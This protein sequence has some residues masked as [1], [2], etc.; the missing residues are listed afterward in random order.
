[1]FDP[2]SSWALVEKLRATTPL[3]QCL[4]NFVSMDVTANVLLAAGASPAMVHDAEESG[5]FVALGGMLSINIGTPSP[6][7]VEGMVA[8][9][10]AAK[11]R[12]TPW[13]LDPVAVGATPYRDRIV[14]S[15]LA[16]RPALIRG[17]GSE[18]MA[19]AGRDDAGVTGVDSSRS[20]A[21]ARGAAIALARRLGAN[22]LVTGKDDLA[23]DGR[24]VVRIANGHPLMT[25]VTALG[26]ALTGVSAAFMAVAPSPLA[27]AV[28]ASAYF[29]VAGEIA[30]ESAAG[31]GSLRVNLLDSFHTLDRERF[32]AR[33]RITLEEP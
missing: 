11:A 28:A 33:A 24:Q 14:E 12:G 6:R 15:L 1:M 17:N 7:W 10:A 23:T 5:A 29:G 32:L 19:M 3:V 2:L 8:A 22:V 26:C 9:A 30:A 27:A 13:V 31:P 4:T 20:S 16:Y 21:D 25:K 18:I